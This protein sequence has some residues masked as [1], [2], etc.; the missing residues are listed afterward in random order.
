MLVIACALLLN[1][2][3]LLLDEPSRGLAPLIVQEVF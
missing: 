1:P 2:K 3:R